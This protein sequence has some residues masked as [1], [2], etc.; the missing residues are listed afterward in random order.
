MFIYIDGQEDGNG[1]VRERTAF[2]KTVIGSGNT[3]YSDFYGTMDEVRIYNRAL[4]PEEV[5][6]NMHRRLA[7]D[8]P[9]LVGYWDFDEGEG[10]IVYDLSGSGNDGQLGSTPNP[11]VSDPA[12]VD[13]DAPIGI[14]SLYQ[15]ATIA[16]DGAVERK[17][18]L[19]EE[20]L[21]ALAQEW[22]AYEALEELLESGDYG[23]LS[24]GDI[25]T[26]KQKIHSAIQHQEQAIDALEKSIEKLKDALWFLGCQ[27]QPQN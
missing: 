3:H 4:S 11:D 19:L 9:G 23:D 14:C 16:A 22:T 17:T 7:G 25:V 13:S 5:W 8:E 21:A 26:A 12:W 1:T 2:T 10:Q 27:V 6:T 20:L 24:K 15:I 18:A